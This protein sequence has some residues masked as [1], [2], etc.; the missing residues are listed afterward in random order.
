MR[1]YHVCILNMSTHPHIFGIETKVDYKRG[2][3]EAL[4]VLA[5][6]VARSVHQVVPDEREWLTLLTGKGVTTT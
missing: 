6:T 1:V 2:A 4:M 5:R 3:M